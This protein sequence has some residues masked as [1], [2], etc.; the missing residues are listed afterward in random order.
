[1]LG[2][3]GQSFLG[4]RLFFAVK[5]TRFHSDI[6]L[7]D[8]L[9]YQNTVYYGSQEEK[10]LISFKIL[11]LMGLGKVEYEMFEQFW[12]KFLQMYSVMFNYK[13]VINE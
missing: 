13:V 2:N 3:L 7:S 5:R 10:D 6:S 9:V 8:F 11:D 12:I 1:M 4:E